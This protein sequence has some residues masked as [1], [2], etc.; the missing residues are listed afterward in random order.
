MPYTTDTDLGRRV[1]LDDWRSVHRDRLLSTLYSMRD[2]CDDEPRLTNDQIAGVT[3]LD[4]KSVSELVESMRAKPKLIA[5][6]ARD[7]T[8]RW[9]ITP[10][11]IRWVEESPRPR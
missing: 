2:L 5:P 6:D 3:G 10:R 4:L 11:G 9:T 8:L 1:R 7:G